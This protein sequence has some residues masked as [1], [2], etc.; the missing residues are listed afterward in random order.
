MRI[1]LNGVAA[2]DQPRALRSREARESR[3]AMLDLPHVAP[4]TAYAV[5]LRSR[6]VG[7]VPDFDP[8]DGGIAAKVLFLFEK[9]GPMTDAHA[10]PGLR[11]GSGFV[12]RDNDD[13]TAEATFRFMRQA[14]VPRTMAVLWNAVPWWNGTTRLSSEELTA[15]ADAA[16]VLLSLLPDLRAIVLVG[17]KARRLAP[18]LAGLKPGLLTSAHPSPI[19][20]ASRPELWNAIPD[21]WS[22]VRPLVEAG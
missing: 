14:G 1:D 20:R 13:P 8:L 2:P 11:M 21:A 3:R 7:T 17:A 12:S 19:V 4:L 18:R 10:P 16:S 9:P 15:G 5:E 22:R 6:G